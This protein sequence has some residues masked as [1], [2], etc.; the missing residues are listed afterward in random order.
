MM[1]TLGI[2]LAGGLSSRYGSPKAFAQADGMAYYEIA[3]NALIGISSQVIIVAR[4][5]HRECY[6]PETNVV[7]DVEPFCGCGPLAGIYSAMTFYPALRYAV[8]PCD[9]PYMHPEVMETLVKYCADEDVIAVQADGMYHPL[10]AIFDQRIK[11]TIRQSL[12]LGQYS[13]MRLLKQVKTTWIQANELTVNT[14]LVFRNMNT[15]E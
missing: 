10:V 1:D 12:E 14:D 11:S 3:V 15:P 2:V 5:E 6:H 9:M 4:E 8:L 13:V 7:T